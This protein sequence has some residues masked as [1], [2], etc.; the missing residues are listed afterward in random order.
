MKL[1]DRKLNLPNSHLEDVCQM[2]N[3]K[4]CFKFFDRF[5]KVHATTNLHVNWLCIHNQ[6]QKK[7]FL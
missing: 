7:I 5:I 4:F 3:N 6:Q 1:P 2:V